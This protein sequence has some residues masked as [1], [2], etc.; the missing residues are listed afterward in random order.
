[1][2][3][4]KLKPETVA[5]LDGLCCASNLVWTE[6]GMFHEYASRVRIHDANIPLALRERWT[7]ATDDMLISPNSQLKLLA[8]FLLAAIGQNPDVPPNSRQMELAKDVLARLYQDLA[9]DWFHIDVTECEYGMDLY[10]C[11]AAESAEDLV[12]LMS[13]WRID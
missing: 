3:A 8:R 11:M 13:R 1:M 7:P 12:C 5:F 10:L 9:F 2:P 6:A 4:R